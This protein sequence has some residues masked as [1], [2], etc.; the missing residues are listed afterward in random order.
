MKLSTG[1][2]IKSIPDFSS[3]DESIKLRW[4]KWIQALRSGE[5]RQGRHLL[6]EGT[7]H[8]CLGVACDLAVADGFASWEASLYPGEFWAIDSRGLH[9]K[10]NLPPGV[11]SWYDMPSN[12]GFVVDVQASTCVGQCSSLSLAGLN[13]VGN[14]TFEDIALILETALAGGLNAASL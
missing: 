10:G 8:C 7:A 2:E 14:A 11:M 13:D 1:L 3:L 12:Q 9:T 5:Y 4:I 6:R